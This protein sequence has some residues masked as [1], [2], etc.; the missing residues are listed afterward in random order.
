M[1]YYGYELPRKNNDIRLKNLQIGINNAKKRELNNLY[2][3]EQTLALNMENLGNN[4]YSSSTSST[5]N[6]SNFNVQDQIANFLNPKSNLKNEL[7]KYKDKKKENTVIAKDLLGEIIQKAETTGKNNFL[8]ELTKKLAS[9]STNSKSTNS[10]STLNKFAELENKKFTKKESPFEAELKQKINEKQETSSNAPTVLSDDDF[11]NLANKISSSLNKE[12]IKDFNDFNKFFNDNPKLFDNLGGSK[13]VST[14]IPIGDEKALSFNTYNKNDLRF[15]QLSYPLF[16]K[17]EK[18]FIEDLLKFNNIFSTTGG[19]LRGGNLVQGRYYNLW[20]PNFGNLHIQHKS[21]K[22]NHLVIT[23]PYSKTQLLGKRNIT[24]L[25][26][27]MI[28]DIANTLEFDKADY[29]NLQK[30]EKVIIEKIVRLQKDMKD[31]NIQKLLDDDDSKIK[32]RLEILV[33][34]VN[35]GNVSSL[36]KKEMKELLKKLYDNKAISNNKYQSSLK[37]LLKLN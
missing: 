32:K 9:K 23:Q 17:D 12:N 10:E 31:V 13:F 5:S 3:Q 4:T 16:Q 36:I 1:V 28:F 22:K 11:N 7:I 15:K 33:G 14:R 20:F 8:D 37:A 24:P 19:G 34:E 35:A 29:H 25:L 26:K 27:K 6:A 2:Q 21:L 30:D 18:K